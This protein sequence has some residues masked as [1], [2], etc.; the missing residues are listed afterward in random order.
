[1]KRIFLG[2]AIH[3]HQPLGN[4]PWVF[5][6]AYQR[7][8]LPMIEALMRHPSVHISLHY[9]G[10][11]ID[12]LLV[13]HPEFFHLL[14][15]LHNSRQI[16]IMGGAYYEPI[17]PAIPIA[18]KFGQI[19]K[20]G[21][22]I[23]AEFGDRPD[24]MWLAERV[25]EPSLASVLSRADIKWTLV[26]DT[27]FKM[28][29]KEEEELT[30]Y[31][32]TEDQGCF[33]KIFPIS[34]YLRYSIPWHKVEEVIEYLKQNASENGDRIAVL[35][36]DGEKFGVWP[37]TFEHCWEEKWVDDFFTALEENSEWLSTTR[38]GDYAAKYPPA[39]RIYLPCASYDEMMEWSLPADKS[40][41]YT[42]LKHQLENHAQL[43]VLRYMQSG[44]WRNFMVRYPEI[45]RMHKKMLLVH[46]KVYRARIVKEG[47]F[48]LDY[49]WKAQCNCPY[50]HGVFGG[51]YLSDIRAVTYSNLVKAEQMADNILHEQDKIHV[52]R[53][54]DFDGDGK[55]ELLVDGEEFNLYVSPAEG[56]SIFEWDL[57]GQAYNLLSTMTRKPEWYHR[58][59]MES[60][61]QTQESTGDKAVK[62]IHDIVRVKDGNLN[63]VPIY[64]KL[65]RSSLIDHF[66]NQG[67]T[68]E[69]FMDNTYFE[70]GNFASA[71]YR[72]VVKAGIVKLAY[73]GVI[74]CG[75]ETGDIKLTKTVTLPEGQ[76]CLNVEYQFVNA[77]KSAIDTIYGCEWNFNLLGGG[78]NDSAYY[79][80]D[81]IDIGDE[82]LDSSGEIGQADHLVMGNRYLGIEVELK[83]ERPLTLWRF[84]VESLSNSEGGIEKVYQANCLLILL[85]LQID[86][87]GEVKFSYSWN[88]NS[89]SP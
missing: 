12:W 9:S 13:A 72:Y 59:L 78:H 17:L 35:G 19:S 61:K 70:A 86:P 32:N 15:G 27:A 47:D 55:V 23:E 31:F 48:G 56:G 20:L 5:E 54:F 38:L 80:V 63:L 87:G 75:Q 10:C 83:L 69:S 68:L 18:D 57:R 53:E 16:E 43:P 42:E 66:F 6:D 62:S 82:H 29:G 1:M 64:D 50:W 40:Y 46:E 14:Q 28:V 34:K 81:G 3:N 73:Q 77:G 88:V 79:R 52:I 25:W 7:A 8:Y 84:P 24:G 67:I 33:L 21:D 37:E 22:F 51:I 41:E 49:L 58:S 89:I 76:S 44:Y 11:L 85:P 4:F 65:P 39:G 30:G 2:L 45:N 36:D 60:G 26:D 74:Q 71:V